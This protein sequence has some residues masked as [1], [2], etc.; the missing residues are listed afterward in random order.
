[1]INRTSEIGDKYT[2][3]TIAA[4]LQSTGKLRRL[5]QKQ[6]SNKVTCTDTHPPHKLQFTMIPTNGPKT[7]TLYLIHYNHLQKT[8]SQANHKPIYTTRTS[9]YPTT[10]QSARHYQHNPQHIQHGI[11]DFLIKQ[12]L[13]WTNLQLLITKT[14]H[15]KSN[16]KFQLHK[17][18]HNL[19]DMPLFK[20]TTNLLSKGLKF[21]PS[22]NP[23]VYRSFL[24][25]RHNMYTKYFFKKKTPP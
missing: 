11:H 23:T 16:N 20:P 9:I 19:S 10:I 6:P 24:N 5:Q 22:P 13:Q 12:Q 8:Q 25:Y 3:C 7:N 2:I 1:M 15:H 21:I 4:S 17:K 18:A 14:L